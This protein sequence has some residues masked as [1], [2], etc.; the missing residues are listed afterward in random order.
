MRQYEE[1]V[2]NERMLQPDTVRCET[3]ELRQKFLSPEKEFTPFPFWFWNDDLDEEE[4]KRQMYEFADK[5]VNGFIIHPRLGLSEK[6]GYLTEKYFHYVRYAVA[7]AKELDMKVILYDEAMYP[8]GSCHGEVVRENPAF[9]SRG[10]RMSDELMSGRNDE[11][12]AVWNR[13]G[14]NWYFI[15]SFSEGTIRGIFEGEDDR[16]PNAPKS[17]DLLNPDAVA[18]F[19]RHTHERYYQELKAYF[20]DTVIAMFTDEPNILG[21]C[22]RENMIPW[23][24]ELLEDFTA[25]GGEVKDLYALFHPEDSENTQR[26][27]EIYQRTIYK[28]MSAAYYGQ[29]ARW[30]REHG[31][32]LIGHPEKSTDIG[33]LQY[34]DI[35]C[36][37]V[38][39]RFVAPEE[40]K[41]IV[42]EHS[43]MAKCS[44]DSA[45]HR[46]KRRNGNECFGCCSRP[47]NLYQLSKADM[48]WYLDW[49]FV[50]G[51]NLIIPHAFYYSL[52]GKRKDE[53]PPEVGMHSGYWEEY[54]QIT[55]YIK[56]MSWLLTDSVNQTA[57]ALLCTSQELSWE[58]AKPLYENQIEFNYL[59]EELLESA[60][61]K[62]GA[63]QV[64]GQEYPVLITDDRVSRDTQQLLEELEKDGVKVIH[65]HRGVD[66]PALTE[67]YVTADMRIQPADSML[68]KTHV[69]KGEISFYLLTNEGDRDIDTSVSIT[70]GKV[71]EIW[72]AWTG[73]A[74]PLKE[75]AARMPIE[76][77]AGE[78][79][80]LVVF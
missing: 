32:G 67:V 75:P 37:D 74:R 46:E 40:E 24:N 33:Y 51:V 9:A 42:G 19:I 69:K 55:D 25:E 64:A 77:K 8:S 6:I 39:W 4:L 21:R 56:R 52:R 12:V 50:R 35:P 29:I 22:A 23:G 2:G 44:S 3:G 28:R 79:R 14:K 78:S 80:I 45:R 71:R 20:G 61:R 43:T 48:K 34:F 73:E 70:E 53:R 49:L 15:E 30:C 59:E 38:V 10:L 68:R 66:L 5:G 18:C 17:V 72:D 60:V 31:I 1:C 54:R 62:K 76:L 26:A 16:E 47:E 7:L 13:N 41:G 36:Q 63:I 11:V 27:R 58:M 65:Y 57:I